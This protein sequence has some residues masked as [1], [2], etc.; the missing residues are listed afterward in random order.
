[1]KPDI[2]AIATPRKWIL[3]GKVGIGSS[4]V[5]AA[6]YI[7]SQWTHLGTISD[8][9]LIAC[10]MLNAVAVLVFGLHITPHIAEMLDAF[11]AAKQPL[12]VRVDAI[13][14]HAW[15]VPF[16][17]LYAAAIGIG[18][19]LADPHSENETL[20]LL[21]SLYL[22]A[23]NLM[24]GFGLFAILRFWFVFL[25]TLPSLQIHILNFNRPP[26]PA[27]LRVNSKI[28]MITAFVASMSVV[29][30]VLSNFQLAGLTVLHSGCLLYTSDA[31]DE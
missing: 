28:V 12:Q 14:N 31:A 8:A 15:A 20:R 25:T 6:L 9:G 5:L 30:V 1:M 10:V 21:L 26:L 2:Q 3:F 22:F 16:A 18:S 13:L 17:L 27:I 4:V 11:P 24:I 23:S 19:W 29:A 7:I